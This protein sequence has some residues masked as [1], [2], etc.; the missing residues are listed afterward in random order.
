[1]EVVTYTDI[2][3]QVLYYFISFLPYFVCYE[4]SKKFTVLFSGEILYFL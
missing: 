2:P 3:T 1:M 4:L